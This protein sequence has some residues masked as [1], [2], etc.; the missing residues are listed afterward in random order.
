MDEVRE[1]IRRYGLEENAEHVIVPFRDRD[2]QLKRCYLLKRR[3]MRLMYPE[4]HFVDYPLAQ[5]IEATVRYPD[6]LLSEALY[7]L[8]KERN[9]GRAHDGQE[10]M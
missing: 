4:G 7:L 8:E 6:L 10:T 5:V 2:G 1:L 9:A 3:Y